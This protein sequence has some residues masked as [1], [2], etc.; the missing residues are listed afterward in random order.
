[1]TSLCSLKT[2]KSSPFEN[3]RGLKNASYQSRVFKPFVSEIG[4][5]VAII[6]APFECLEAL[7]CY[8]YLHGS[9]G[10]PKIPMTCLVCTSMQ[11]IDVWEAEAA[12]F[13]I[14]G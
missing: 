5:W 9:L 4:I 11:K 13:S 12:K 8:Y 1:M 6:A 7:F 14:F 2:F 10:I 3:I